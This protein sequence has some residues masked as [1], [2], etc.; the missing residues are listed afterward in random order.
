MAIFLSIVSDGTLAQHGRESKAGLL[1]PSNG[2]VVHGLD[3][4]LV[5]SIRGKR[6]RQG[7]IMAFG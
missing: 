5:L 6:E 7:D 1:V 4:L 2:L 3:E